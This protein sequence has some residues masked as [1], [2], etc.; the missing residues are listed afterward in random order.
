MQRCLCNP[1]AGWDESKYDPHCDMINNSMNRENITETYCVT[2]NIRLPFFQKVHCQ[3]WLRYLTGKKAPHVMHTK[4]LKHICSS[5]SSQSLHSVISVKMHAEITLN[6]DTFTSEVNV[7]WLKMQSRWAVHCFGN[8][9]VCKRE[10]K[11]RDGNTLRFCPQHE[12]LKIC[13]RSECTMENYC[14][15]TLI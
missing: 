12:M 3:H 11:K 1:L 10:R 15:S 7:L 5:I 6:L 4:E 8:T 14:F 9:N 13:M 2:Y